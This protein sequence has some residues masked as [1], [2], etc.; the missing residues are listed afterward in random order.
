[1]RQISI[2][3]GHSYTTPEMALQAVSLDTLAQYM[4][5]DTREQ[6]HME[7]APCSDLV[8]L[9]EYLERAPYDLIFG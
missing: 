6:V 9:R 8:F 7:L 4:D 1:M 2:D 5:D 3:N